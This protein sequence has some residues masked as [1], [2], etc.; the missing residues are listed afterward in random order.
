M[1][2][3]TF[4]FVILTIHFLAVISP[5]PDFVMAVKNSLNY[6]RKIGVFTAA[7]FALGIVVHL[8]Y[9]Y[10]GVAVAISQIPILFNLIKIIGAI[11]LLY[12]A[13]E[14]F[15]HRSD[16]AHVDLSSHDKT[17]ITELQAVR[18]GFWTNLL[19]PKAT[20]FFL[21]LFTTAVPASVGKSVL[22]L[23][24]AGMVANTFLW[25][26]LVSIV[27]TQSKSLEVFQKYAVHINTTLAILLTLLSVKILFF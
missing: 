26:T 15:L 6:G 24:C 12:V 25:F 10:I 13:Y 18:V 23:V 4:I 2:N 5:G 7:G 21:G 19:N 27:F 16:V 14:I 20:L 11:Y 1:E 9:C 17:T 22:L 3:L 8:F